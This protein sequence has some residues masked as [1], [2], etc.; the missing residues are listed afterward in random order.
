M[1]TNGVNLNFSDLRWTYPQYKFQFFGAGAHF[2]GPT[3]G[4]NSIRV[5]SNSLIQISAPAVFSYTNA[6]SSCVFL[7]NASSR[8][9]FLYK[10]LIQ[11]CFH[12]QM[13]PQS[14]FSY[15]SVSSSCVFLYNISVSVSCIFIYKCLRQLCFPIQMSPPAVSS[16][17]S[18]V[19]QYKCFLQLCFP[20]QLLHPT[21]FPYTNVSSSCVSLTSL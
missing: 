15:T 10:C 13:S 14:V 7:T 12:I 3:L 2:R 19:F 21:V 5:S 6:S 4:V 17:P 1:P 11:L 16:S 18:C 9:V 8:C 20:I